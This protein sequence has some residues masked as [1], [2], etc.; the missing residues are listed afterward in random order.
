[1]HSLFILENLKISTFGISGGVS[2]PHPLN[3][4][5]RS[6]GALF[7]QLCPWLYYSI[8]TS[9]FYIGQSDWKIIPLSIFSTSSSAVRFSTVLD[10]TVFTSPFKTNIIF[11]IV[12]RIHTFLILSISGLT[13]RI[14]KPEDYEQSVAR[15]GKTYKYGTI[16]CI[17]L[18]TGFSYASKIII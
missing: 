5:R 4:F 9:I 1:M 11:N 6:A 13:I 17:M 2:H 7:L 16:I 12:R 3:N 15:Q 8:L 10:Q 18:F 14:N